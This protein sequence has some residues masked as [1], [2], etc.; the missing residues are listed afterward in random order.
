MITNGVILES[1][2]VGDPGV[3]GGQRG[4]RPRDWDLHPYGS[5]PYTKPFPD[6]L[7]IPRSEWDTR[8]SAMNTNAT[9]LAAKVKATGWTVFNQGQTNYCWANAICAAME[10]VRI[11]MN[12]PHVRLSSASVAAI[13][14]DFNNWG[15][16]G[17]EANAFCVERGCATHATWPNAVIRP[18]QAAIQQAETEREHFRVVEFYEIPPGDQDAFMSAL[19]LNMV[20]APGYDW[21]RHQVTACSP[22]K[23][24]DGI[25]GSHGPN[26]WGRNWGEDGWYY[27]EGSKSIPDDCV[28]MHTVTPSPGP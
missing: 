12:E 16:W 5:I 2:H 28:V 21:W 14:K 8:Y 17:H 6:H 19:F 4:Y 24:P 10:I 27:L 26:S 13:I 7:R 20:A 11:N 3:V 23:S 9:S 22:W 15:G 18:S 25:W 1:T